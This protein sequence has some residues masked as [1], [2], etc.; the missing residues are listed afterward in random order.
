MLQGKEEVPGT[1]PDSH[2]QPSLRLSQPS[3]SLGLEVQMKVLSFSEEE[4]QGV[5]KITDSRESSHSP[6]SLI[7]I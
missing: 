7:L 5:E 1:Q 6:T 3:S 2:A 4:R